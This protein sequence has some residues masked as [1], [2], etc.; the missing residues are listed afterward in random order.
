[1]TNFADILKRAFCSKTMCT[2]Q[3]QPVWSAL[4]VLAKSL[5]IVL[6]KIYFIV[7]FVYQNSMKQFLQLFN[8]N[9]AY[10]HFNSNTDASVLPAI[11]FFFFFDHLFLRSPGHHD[12]LT[13]DGYFKDCH[14]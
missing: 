13:H 14:L 7:N 5:K 11:F 2:L 10:T 1:M 8:Q 6:R 3:K 9:F 12:R 4:K